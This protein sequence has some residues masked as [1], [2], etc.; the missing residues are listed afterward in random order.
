MVTSV[1]VSLGV[2]AFVAWGATGNIDWVV[3]FFRIP[4]AVLLIW[5]AV[6]EFWLSLRVRQCFV[7]GDRL[8]DA[9]TYISLSALCQLLGAICSQL[10]S[11]NEPLNPL[12]H[13]PIW[14]DAA[15]GA[16]R[17]LG[18][19]FGGT[20]R[21]GL[22]AAGLFTILRTHRK[23]G[24]TGRLRR[25]DWLLL[26]AAG[27]YIAWEFVGVVVAFKQGKVMNLAEAMSWPVDPLLLFLLATALMLH[28]SV[29]AMDAHWISRC[30]R[31]Y[32][33]AIA[34]VLLADLGLWLTQ[35]GFLTWPTSSVIWCI[36]L[37][38]ACGF[39]LAPAYQLE[40]IHHATAHPANPLHSST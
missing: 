6:I 30:W 20:I 8:H 1:Y 31:S 14:S 27:A 7:V 24:F 25:I 17:D 19:A 22:L 29:G 26:A 2:V 39:A 12:S 21:Y 33:I 9:W 28:R 36:W 32:G 34:L 5:L 3:R 38:A 15:A 16:V 11:L 10:L 18:L 35:F 40:T 13:L 23:E 4:E 37:P